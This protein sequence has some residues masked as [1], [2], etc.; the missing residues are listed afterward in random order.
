MFP[1]WSLPGL[2]NMNVRRPTD[3]LYS[4]LS[5]MFK[6][7][8]VYNLPVGMMQRF[9]H[10]SRGPPPPGGAPPLPL[11]SSEESEPLDSEPWYFRGDWPWGPPLGLMPPKPPEGSEARLL[12][13]PPFGDLPPRPAPA[14]SMPPSLLAASSSWARVCARLFDWNFKRWVRGLLTWTLSAYTGMVKRTWSRSSSLLRNIISNSHERCCNSTSWDS[15][16]SSN[17]GT[18]DCLRCS[19]F[20]FRSFADARRMMS[21]AAGP[22]RWKCLIMQSNLAFGGTFCGRRW[23]NSPIQYDANLTSVS[24]I[25][26]RWLDKFWNALP[27]AWA[28]KRCFSCSLVPSSKPVTTCTTRYQTSSDTDSGALSSILNTTST[29]HVKFGAFRSARI[30][31]FKT[32]S[33]CSSASLTPRSSRS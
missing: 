8:D 11:P 28:C 18:T 7:L 15:C 33:S 32:S 5:S 20:A 21:F 30:A 27:A 1:M 24:W 17:I 25:M 14:L 31:I 26:A 6:L 23:P 13:S 29:Y 12:S 2:M 3:V 10:S 16:K 9:C 19:G 22:T 4:C